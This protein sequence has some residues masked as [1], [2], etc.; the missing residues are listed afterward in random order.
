VALDATG[1]ARV[2]AQWMRENTIDVSGFSKAD[3]AAA[4]AAVDD[5]IDANQ[6]SFNQALPAAFRTGATTVQKA[7]LFAFVLWRRI[8]RLRAEEDG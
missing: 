5:W 7:W 8:G 6:T 3:L 1:R 2:T 4:V